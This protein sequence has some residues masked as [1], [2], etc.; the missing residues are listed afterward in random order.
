MGFDPL[1]LMFLK[2]TEIEFAQLG[3]DVKS[4]AVP[5]AV[6]AVPAVNGCDNF[7]GV[8]DPS[9]GSEEN[10]PMLETLPFASTTTCGMAFDV[11]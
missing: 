11:P 3:I 10:V 9:D 5:V 1:V 4:T 6:T 2:I 8:I 7:A